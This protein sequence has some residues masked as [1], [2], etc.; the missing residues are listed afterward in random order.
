MAAEYT[1][2][3]LGY[4]GDGVVQCLA[5]RDCELCNVFTDR[6]RSNA[7]AVRKLSKQGDDCGWCVA[8]GTTVCTSCNHI[9]WL[10]AKK[11]KEETTLRYCT[12][13]MHCA[14]CN[15]AMCTVCWAQSP[16]T[17]QCYACTQPPELNLATPYVIVCAD[18]AG[19]A[20]WENAVP[21]EL[22]VASGLVAGAYGTAVFGTI[23]GK[24]TMVVV[25]FT[26]PPPKDERLPISRQR[27]YQGSLLDNFHHPA[28]DAVVARS[29]EKHYHFTPVADSSATLR[30]LCG[31][32]YS[33]PMRVYNV[34]DQLRGFSYATVMPYVGRQ[35][36]KYI[37]AEDDDPTQGVVTLDNPV[38][39]SD[40]QP[41]DNAPEIPV[42]VLLYALL[43]CVRL[44]YRMV[45][46]LRVSHIDMH[47]GN[48]MINRRTDG[49]WTV[50]VIDLGLLSPTDATAWSITPLHKLTGAPDHRVSKTD[51]L[52]FH[53]PAAT[54]YTDTLDSILLIFE[55]IARGYED[56]TKRLTIKTSA[57]EQQRL[58]RFDDAY[59]SCVGLINRHRARFPMAY[60]VS[61]K[62]TVTRTYSGSSK[63]RDIVGDDYSEAISQAVRGDCGMFQLDENNIA[64]PVLDKKGNT[65]KSSFLNTLRGIEAILVNLWNANRG[66]ETEPARNN[67]PMMFV[68]SRAHDGH[69]HPVPLGDV[70]HCRLGVL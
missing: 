22:S 5:R 28:T 7:S 36:A 6:V 37:C 61:K 58:F 10:L 53:S 9:M 16:D 69:A 32:L 38:Y 31:V 50:S 49:T 40:A 68:S 47:P 42:R 70:E 12:P 25:K 66:S 62:T 29:I 63:T 11:M 46:R 55:K 20:S 39:F 17:R 33:G 56:T 48:I 51:T 45:T 52:I 3:L 26:R 19:D 23:V 65:C 4:L 59:D 30:G 14:T 64:Q 35:L 60:I 27:V 44:E 1:G 8:D 34:P 41:D 21:I 54:M 18:P 15:T 43:H 57:P 24:D 2:D 13:D 67:A